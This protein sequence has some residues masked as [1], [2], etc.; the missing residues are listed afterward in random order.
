MDFVAFLQAESELRDK[1]I[2]EKNIAEKYAE[3]HNL[4]LVSKEFI[5]NIKSDIL[6][7][8]SYGKVEG[9]DTRSL[10]DVIEIF[11]KHTKG[12]TENGI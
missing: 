12:D 11:D 2:K 8:N 7:A 5:D 4:M 3:E 1:Q 6:K 10:D 9:I